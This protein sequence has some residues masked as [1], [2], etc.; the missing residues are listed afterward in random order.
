MLNCKPLHPLFAAEVVGVDLRQ[1]HDPAMLAAIRAAMDQ[2]AVLVFRDQPFTDT[3]QVEFA[4][5]FDG[6]LHTQTSLSAL[7]TN[8]FG[9]EALTDISSVRAN[10]E[11]ADTADRR[12]LSI[13]SNRLWHTDASFVDP[14]GRYS[15]LSA[16]VVPEV[17]ADTEFADMRSAWDALDADEQRRIE[18]LRVFHSIV[19]S[20]HTIGFDFSAEE[21]ARLPGA[22]HPLVRTLPGS[23]RRSLYL[24][25]HAS[26]IVDWPVPEGRILLLDLVEHATQPQFIYRHIWQ[27]RD[28]VIW[29]N[30]ATMHR[31]RP[32][33]DTRYRR[34]LRRTTTLDVAL[35]AQS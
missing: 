15:L 5:R 13:L 20:R 27:P 22:V 3:E 32:F 1:A 6:R 9:N 16:R 7:G 25:S 17:R 8:R 35:P 10:G 21:S 19:H 11:L 2:H 34:E 14:P 12:R 4:S 29:D 31:A 23:G 30:R 24:A 28:L 33:D 26:H 18:G